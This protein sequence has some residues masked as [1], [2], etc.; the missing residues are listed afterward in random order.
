[1]NT[2]CHSSVDL[3]PF[4][5]AACLATLKVASIIPLLPSAIKAKR[6]V[7]L[8]GV[9][10]KIR[11]KDFDDII[12]DLCHHNEFAVDNIDSLFKFP[13]W[14]IIKIVFKGTAP[15]IK[16]TEQGLK[17]YNMRVPPHRIRR[18]EY[19]PI[20]IC[21]RCYA[22]ASHQTQDCPKPRAHR[23]C[24]ECAEEGHRFTACPLLLKEMSQLW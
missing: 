15:A 11:R 13:S 23:V 5:R 10:E 3:P 14:P 20:P 17:M 19:V 2:Q 6:T 4:F 8:F 12:D 16:A 7:P 24:S 9:D 1:M 21:M 18:E 22:L